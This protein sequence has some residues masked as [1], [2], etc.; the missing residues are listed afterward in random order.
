MTAVAPRRSERPTGIPVRRPQVDLANAD[1]D[2]WVVPGDPVL[3]HIMTAL[4]AVFPNGEDFFVQSVRNYRDRFETDPEMKAKVKGFVGQESMHGREHR[5]FNQRL[6][7][8]GYP[9]VWLDAG[10]LKAATRAQR[11]PKSWQLSITAASE[12]LTSVF[13]HAVLSDA[14]TRS[15]LFPAPD[16]DLLITW[17][18]LEELEHKDVAF[19]VLQTVRRS[20]VLRVWGMALAAVYWGPVVVS[21]VV[22]GLAKDRRDLTPRALRQGARD[23]RRQRM[24]GPWS[25]VRIARYLQPGFHPRQVKTDA[26]VVEWRERL[27]PRMSSRPVAAAGVVD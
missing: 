8:L 15:T 9:T 5:L 19:D 13:A 21:G 7:A 4:S 20:Y 1:V 17:H 3:S 18:A 10:L 6:A 14:Q 25:W 12:H 22:R 11:L 26:L 16:A 2:R 23:Y 27:E 24:L